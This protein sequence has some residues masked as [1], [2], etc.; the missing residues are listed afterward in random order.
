M[1]HGELCRQLAEE[2]QAALTASGGVAEYSLGLREVLSARGGILSKSPRLR[3]AGFVLGTCESASSDTCNHVLPA[4]AALEILAAALELFDDLEDYDSRQF[5]TRR[6]RALAT[7][8]AYG[9]VMASQ[10]CLLR[11]RHHQK[12][13][14]KLPIISQLFLETAVRMGGGQQLDLLHE[15][16]VNTTQDEC[17][18]IASLKSAELVKCAFKIG[19]ILGTDDEHLIELYTQFGWHLGMFA[20]IVNDIEGIP[21]GRTAKSDV[22]R[23]KATLPIAFWLSGEGAATPRDSKHLPL[24]KAEEARVRGEIRRSGALHYAWVIADMHRERAKEILLELD[25]FR[26]ASSILGSFVEPIEPGSVIT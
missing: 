8:V 2:V 19:A 15:G 3:W 6:E 20:Q 7:N 9:L 10:L 17:L 5:K 24:S 11:L 1:D 18:A 14:E 13:A 4:G 26:P 21:S 23:L 25:N 22:S 12:A 16:C